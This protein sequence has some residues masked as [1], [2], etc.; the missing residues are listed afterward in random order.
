MKYEKNVRIQSCSFQKDLQILFHTVSEKTHEPEKLRV[1]RKP[2][3]LN[4][5]RKNKFFS[6][7]DH[8]VD[9][10][11]GRLPFRYKTERKLI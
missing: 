4:L 9:S 5:G 7:F 8:G 10:Q 3:N 11:Y 6:L 2:V 1:S